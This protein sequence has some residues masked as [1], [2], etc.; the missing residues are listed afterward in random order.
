MKFLKL[1]NRHK[2]KII[3]ILLII[4]AVV[5]FS[6]YKK[7]PQV[8][9][10]ILTET[11]RIGNIQQTLRKDGTISP[12]NSVEINST[13]DGRIKEIFV[14]EGD[15]VKKGQKLLTITP[16]QNI[17]EKYV[18]IDIYAPMD[19]L[20]LRCLNDRV[21]SR[22]KI[23][24]ELPQLEE[25]IQGSSSS[26]ATCLMKIIKNDTYVLPFKVDEFNIAKIYLGMPLKI[27]VS[28]K[29]DL[30]IDGFI[31]LIS[32]QPEIKE[33]N[34]WSD[35]NNKVEFIVV[36]ETKNYK[37]PL[38]IGLTATAE[39]D[40]DKKENILTVPLNAVY[41]DRNRFTKEMKYFIHKKVGAK[42]AEKIEIKL[43][44]KDEQN[45][46]ILEPEKLNLKEND[47]LFIDIKGDDIEFVNEEKKDTKTPAK[48]NI[49]KGKAVRK[50]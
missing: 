7:K 1:L 3:S 43:G 44:L 8:K 23:S 6:F 15:I 10:E 4:A 41:E 17:Y 49:K 36:A 38:I 30:D 28:S 16:G 32:P 27:K 26:N 47:E 40:L 13:A 9:D 35:E 33:E 37:G 5:Y 24:Y 50:K 25:Y 22:S 29:P 18:P 45:A 12:K 34:R 20:V 21:S 46:E 11:L 19:G 14:K 42:K 39:I 48:D 31:S 2:G